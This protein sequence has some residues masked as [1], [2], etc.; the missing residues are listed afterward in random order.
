LSG[1]GGAGPSYD[2]TSRN[3]THGQAEKGPAVH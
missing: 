2:S 3:S 1:L